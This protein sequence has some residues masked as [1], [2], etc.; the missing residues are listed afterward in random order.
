[1]TVDMGVATEVPEMDL[2]LLWL[3]VGGSIGSSV[4]R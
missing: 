1:M 2:V 4:K 3:Q